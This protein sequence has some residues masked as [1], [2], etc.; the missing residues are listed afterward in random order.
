MAQT[1]ANL[2]SELRSSYMTRRS[3]Q[4]PDPGAV[5]LREGPRLVREEHER[6]AG[7][8]AV[9]RAVGARPWPQQILRDEG[10]GAARVDE[11]ARLL[12]FRCVAERPL[13]R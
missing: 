7:R 9:L 1:L 12:A 2:V 11:R 4:A 5:A 3:L 6:A 13:P 10:S 8:V